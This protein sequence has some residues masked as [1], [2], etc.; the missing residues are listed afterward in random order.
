MSPAI[1]LPPLILLS[2]ISLGYSAFIQNRLIQNILRGLRILA[3]DQHR[4]QVVG[5]HHSIFKLRDFLGHVVTVHIDL[6]C[7]KEF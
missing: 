5:D 1:L 7:H 3:N 6:V 2:L 4:L